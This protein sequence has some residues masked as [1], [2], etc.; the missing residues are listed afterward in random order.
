[1]SNFFDYDYD[2]FSNIDSTASEQHFKMAKFDII[3]IILVAKSRISCELSKLSKRIVTEL[4]TKQ[5]CFNPVISICNL[6]VI[7]RKVNVRF[8]RHCVKEFVVNFQ[9]MSYLV[10][11]HLFCVNRDS[12][13]F[14]RYDCLKSAIS[15]N[16]VQKSSWN[17]WTQ[18]KINLPGTCRANGALL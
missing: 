15:R 5:H 3:T 12:F 11:N 9:L 17:V 10:Y 18:A 7:V 16:S 2:N 14:I 8:Y 4:L 1:M 13:L 6:C